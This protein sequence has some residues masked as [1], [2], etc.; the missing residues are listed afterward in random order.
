[1]KLRRL[2]LWVFVIGLCSA[3]GGAFYVY[4]HLTDGEYLRGRVIGELGRYFPGTSISVGRVYLRVLGGIQIADLRV[5]QQLPYGSVETVAAESVTIQ[6]EAAPADG[7]ALGIESIVIRNGRLRLVQSREGRWNVEDLVS[8]A[9]RRQHLPSISL[10]DCAVEV[11]PA[12]E[13]LAPAC[14]LEKISAEL[15]PE[16]DR[17]YAIEAQ[18]TG[19]DFR[20]LVARGRWDLRKQTLELGGA[21]DEI[22]VGPKLAERLPRSLR[23]L[24]AELGVVAGQARC[25]YTLHHNPSAPVPW[26]YEVTAQLS[27]G[28]VEHRGLPCPLRDVSATVVC[29]PEGAELR[30]LRAFHDSTGVTATGRL[31]GYQSEAPYELSADIKN[32]IIEDSIFDK[33]PKKLAADIRE[34]QPAGRANLTAQLARNRQETT[35]AITLTALDGSMAYID[36]PYRLDRIKG[37]VKFDKQLLAIDLTGY[38]GDRPVQVSGVVNEPGPMSKVRVD[39]V[40]AS[41]PIDE[42]LLRA[43]GPDERK[44]V[45]QLGLAGDVA[46][47]IRLRRTEASA[48]RFVNH[49]T[50]KPLACRA[51]YA[52]LPYRIDDIRGAVEIYPDHWETVELVGRHGAAQFSAAARGVPGGDNS[53][54]H[55]SLTGTGVVLDSALRGALGKEWRDVWDQVSPAGRFDFTAEVRS[56]GGQP[57]QVDAAVTLAGVSLLP[58]AL[59]YRLDDL[60]GSVRYRPDE[61]TLTRLS[62]RH[63]STRWKADGQV[64]R[65]ETGTLRLDLF[66]LEADRLVFDADLLAALPPGARAIAGGVNPATPQGRPA[67]TLGLA[68]NLTLKWSPHEPRPPSYA[69]SGKASIKGGRLAAG[70]DLD[71]IDGQIISSGSYDAGRLRGR[72]RLDVESLRVL[73]E[74]ITD[75]H[76]SFSLVGSEL[77]LGDPVQEELHARVL[78]GQLGGQIRLTLDDSRIVHCRLHANQINLRHYALKHLEA[79][80]RLQGQMTATLVLTGQAS[81]RETL[82]GGGVIQVEKGDIYQLPLVVGLLKVLNLNLPNT[83]GFDRAY[84][85]Y[86]IADGRVQVHR[87]DLMGDAISLRGRGDVEF[88]GRIAL[89]FY[90]R[91]GRVG[92]S[93]LQLPLVSMILGETSRQL[94]RIKATGTLEKPLL[95]R[96]W[97]PVVSEPLKKFLD[98]LESGARGEWP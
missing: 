69:W 61:I 87:I 97:V 88:D 56:Q 29:R 49:I 19:Q 20:S 58:R 51:A 53:A 23:P 94:L 34:F 74:E 22:L 75:L 6:Q 89:T 55:L 7:R 39:A 80:H 1:M 68:T 79:P 42:K 10:R 2:L 38:S 65:T 84:V 4:Q 48:P 77:V 64:L 15:V 32:L 70:L 43:L 3:A 27:G 93:D 90:T 86:Q 8:P 21:L 16:D 62:A 41:L 76:S 37:T 24:W 91:V 31:H 14:D 54:A 81:Q 12:D 11:R 95:D 46:V 83:K 82:R 26:T 71:A 30:A 66:G 59:P 9:A 96:D 98:R 13:G 40:A 5:R 73:G 28:R 44:I 85:D 18:A 72:G 35:A 36:F 57:P 25:E 63:G 33:L 52:E 78:G 67:G 17:A 47:H 92:R 45:S 50:A 60:R